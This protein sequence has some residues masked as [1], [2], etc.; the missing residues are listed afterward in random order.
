MYIHFSHTY[1]HVKTCINILTQKSTT[2]LSYHSLSS[3]AL[4]TD[5]CYGRRAFGLSDWPSKVIYVLTS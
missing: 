4:M 1:I 3:G 2:V 5:V